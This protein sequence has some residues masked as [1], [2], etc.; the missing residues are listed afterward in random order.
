MKEQSVETFTR[1]KLLE[2]CLIRLWKLFFLFASYFFICCLLLISFWSDFWS[3]FCC[4]LSTGPHSSAFHCSLLLLQ[5]RLLSFLPPMRNLFADSYRA[6][7]SGSKQHRQE[8]WNWNWL[9][10]YMCSLESTVGI[11]QIKIYIDLEKLFSLAFFLSFSLSSF[12][13]SLSMQKQFETK[14]NKKWRSEAKLNTQHTD[15]LTFFFSSKLFFV[16]FRLLT[17]WMTDTFQESWAGMNYWK[18]WRNY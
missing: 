15:F 16:S 3:A 12:L 13:N 14:R 6:S 9:L 2:F 1:S 4:S 17:R 5:I 8:W 10:Y 7:A 18:K 11:R